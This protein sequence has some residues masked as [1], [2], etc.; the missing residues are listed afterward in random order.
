MRTVLKKWISV[1][2]ALVLVIQLLPASAVAADGDDEILIIETEEE[3]SEGGEDEIH[4]IDEEEELE[5]TEEIDLESNGAPRYTAADVLWENDMLR[6][7]S[8]K[9]F[10]ISD[11]SEMAIVYA[12]PVH[13]RNADGAYQ[14]ID[15]TLVLC[16]RGEWPLQPKAEPA[17]IPA[18][19]EEPTV[20]IKPEEPDE[21]VVIIEI[22]PVDEAIDNAAPE[23]GEDDDEL[24]DK[25]YRNKAGLLDV[26]L[27]ALS[28]A[29]DLVM[30]SD[31]E[32]TIS[33]TP[34]WE[35]KRS[36]AV[37]LEQVFPYD[38]ESF[39]A[40]I[41]PKTLNG[42]LRYEEISAGLDLEYCVQP[43][44]VKETLTLWGPEYGSSF[45]FLMD[46]GD[47]LP[48]IGEDGSILFYD[49]AGESVMMI[50]AGYMTDALGAFSDAITYDL[51]PWE[52]GRY[53]F[54]ISADE[55][56][57]T[58]EERAYPVSIDPSLTRYG[59]AYNRI[60]CATI[61]NRTP[62]DTATLNV[63]AR[64]GGQ[65]Y[66]D[67]GSV[68]LMRTLV[69]INDVPTL[70]SNSVVVN[71][72]FRLLQS[73]FQYT[74]TDS[75]TIVARE[76]STNSPINNWWCFGKSW[77]TAPAPVEEILDYA[78]VNS[79]STY[80]NWD[81]TRYALKWYEDSAN[82]YGF[83]LMAANETDF[84]SS[85][86][87]RAAFLG[88]SSLEEEAPYFEVQYRNTVG[89]ENYY[90]YHTHSIDRA[91]SAYVSDMSR[92]LTL[93]KTDVSK[94]S[95]VNP[96]VLSHVYNTAYSG[97]EYSGQV[98]NA[99]N[100]YSSMKV[101][102]GWKL[103]AQQTCSFYENGC[104]S[105][106]D[107]DGTTHFLKRVVEGVFLDEDGLGLTAV[108]SGGNGYYNFSTNYTLSDPY[109]NIKYFQAGTLQYEQD[110]DG[111]RITYV[112]DN[113]GRITSVVRKNHG[114]TE[115]IVATLS[116]SGNRLS[117]VT[118]YAGNTTSFTYTGNYLT[119]ITHADGTSVSYTYDSSGK[120]LSATDNESVYKVNY[121]WL[122]GKMTNM[123]ERGSVASGASVTIGSP[124]GIT[125]YR[126]SG[127]NRTAGD[128][129]DLIEN[130]VFDFSGV[131]SRAIRPMRLETES[132][133]RRA[134]N[135]RSVRRLA[136]AIT[137][138]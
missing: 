82:N 60:E 14:D 93:V 33:F 96:F 102:Y 126:T 101:G 50:P 75:L 42:S 127:C 123:Q 68:A 113:D 26:R 45:S 2:L 55:G 76:L 43:C 99:G 22:D 29:E 34:A 24:L 136:A 66:S 48:M 81:I 80:S 23:K 63:E 58:E 19:P 133:A 128:A 119:G 16:E 111:N 118:D 84:S 78:T 86:N 112:F 129:D 107:A 13:Y 5:P 94:A 125:S 117:S 121:T 39:E 110:A 35:V 115:E 32:H 20:P 4:L 53:L 15:N 124:G 87:A 1:L 44:G 61:Q 109:G 74:G 72:N 62:T 38:S 79:N 95:T 17:D 134:E 27:A 51:E 25:E 108:A 64:V 114:G 130:C 120:M 36:P 85:S 6:E 40:A 122:N 100:R 131:R 71:A 47:L 31:G 103:S 7:A 46:L 37:V 104:L 83:V 69:R 56:W 135:T 59:T 105:Y 132:T 8:A 97:G 91:G 137:G 70:P 88:N 12:S 89:V 98:L 11:G 73:T 30:L 116:Y 52:D 65:Y 92:Q 41:M 3:E 90:S 77:N 138:C 10:H 21:D 57:L 28:D 67:T 18:E 54:T 9:H 49:N 106:C